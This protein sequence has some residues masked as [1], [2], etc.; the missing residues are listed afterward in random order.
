[1]E[2]SPLRDTNIMAWSPSLACKIYN[3]VKEKGSDKHTSVLLCANYGRKQFNST[4]PR[5][6]SECSSLASLYSLGV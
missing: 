6:V 2:C 1:M 5:L 3:G 4:G